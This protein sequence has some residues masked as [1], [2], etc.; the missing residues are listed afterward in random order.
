MAKNLAISI[1]SETNVS[2]LVVKGDL[3]FFV[4][5]FVSCF[6]GMEMRLKGQ[7]KCLSG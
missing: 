7:N 1:S 4:L 2:T 5:F 3:C 6:R